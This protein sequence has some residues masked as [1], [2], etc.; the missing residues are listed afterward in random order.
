MPKLTVVGVRNAKPGRHADGGGL[1]LLVKPSGARSWL[2][3]YQVAGQRRDIGLGAVS[4]L[5]LQEAREKAAQLRK[6]A[7]NGGDPIAERDRERRPVPTFR[8]AAKACHEEMKR[9]WEP[10]HAAS[11]LSSLEEHAYSALGNTRVDM[12]EASNV[13]DALAPIWIDKPVMA[14]KVRQRIGAV[15]N[16]AKSKGWRASEAPTRSVTVGL[17]RQPKGGNFAAMPYAEV[18]AF[19]QAVREASETVGRMALLFTILTAARSGEVRSARWSH[20]DF[21]AALWRRP[22]ALMKSREAHDVTLNPAAFAILERAAMLRTTKGDALIF[23]G[24]SG[25]PLSDMT[26]T[27]ALRD[28]GQTCTVHGFRSSFRDWCAEQMPGT[29][30]AVAEAALAH[31]VPDAVVRAYKRTKFLDMRRGLLNAWGAFVDGEQGGNV[32]AIRA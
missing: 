20:I 9:G 28:A 25:K 22:A 2:L 12:I 24:K 13:R 18:P 3:R 5:T 26:L 27:K 23:P 30:E 8:I 6:V 29:P 16:F 7:R 11:W 32:V 14:R 19:V 15:L 21:E 17:S 1:Y 31:V 4:D 10:K